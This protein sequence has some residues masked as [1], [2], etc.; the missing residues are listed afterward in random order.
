[1]RLAIFET[2]NGAEADRR[3]WCAVDELDALGP[4]DGLPDASALQRL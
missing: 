3:I 4:I 2:M 1:M